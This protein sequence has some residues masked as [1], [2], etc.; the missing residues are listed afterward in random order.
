[1]RRLRPALWLP[2][3]DDL[4]PTV[5]AAEAEAAGVGRLLRVGSAELVARSGWSP[6]RGS[7]ELFDTGF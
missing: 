5:L 7:R 1:M 4:D 6:T 2:L 3:V